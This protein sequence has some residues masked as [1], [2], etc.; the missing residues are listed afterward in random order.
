[1]SPTIRRKLKSL[2]EKLCC[3]NTF[4]TFQFGGLKNRK[5]RGARAGSQLPK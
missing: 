3:T 4:L 1:M 2:Y 5:G